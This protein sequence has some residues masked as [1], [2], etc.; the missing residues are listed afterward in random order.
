MLKNLLQLIQSVD[1]DVKICFYLNGGDG[2]PF[3]T[4]SGE[5][6]FTDNLREILQPYLNYNA[7]IIIYSG[8]ISVFLTK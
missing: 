4:P 6:F 8:E 1:D 2:E 5:D 7:E 3:Y